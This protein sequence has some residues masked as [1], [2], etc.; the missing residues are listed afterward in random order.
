[1]RAWEWIRRETCL[2][3]IGSSVN[4]TFTSVLMIP[5]SPQFYRCGLKI[6]LRTNDREFPVMQTSV[7]YSILRWKVFLSNKSLGLPEKWNYSL[8]I[9]YRKHFTVITCHSLSRAPLSLNVLHNSKSGK[10][11]TNFYENCNRK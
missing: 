7:S 11:P 10:N 2:F 8:K 4:T 3:S 1:M 5:T 9:R 6:A